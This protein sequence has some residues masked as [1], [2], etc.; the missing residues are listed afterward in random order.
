MKIEKIIDNLLKEPI[1]HHLCDSGG[2]YGYQYER[3]QNEGYVKGL[4]PVDHY[5]NK[6]ERILEVNIP[7]YDFLTYN[8]VKD[9]D[10]I[11]FEKQ[12]FIELENHN[13]NPYH[14]FEVAEFL[15][16]NLFTGI[17]I[18][19]EVKYINTYNYEEYLSQTL[20]Y[21][22]IYDGLDWYILL[23]LHNGCDVRSGYTSPQIFK[24]KDIDCFLIGQFERK[25]ECECGLN[26]YRLYRNEITD[27]NGNVDGWDIYNRTFIDDEDYVRCKDCKKIIKGGFVEW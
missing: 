4:I 11:N 13:I 1:A 18:E 24:V 22:P 6:E 23:E 14:I 8:L 16:S 12:L 21:A 3:N 20:L 15:N 27:S 2:A 26:D 5:T 10:A 7:I 17:N 9:E 25:T 19:N